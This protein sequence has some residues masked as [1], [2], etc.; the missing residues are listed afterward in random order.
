M[1]TAPLMVA[2]YDRVFV[3]ESFGESWRRRGRLY[4]GLAA[5]WALL[6]AVIASGP[7]FRSAGFG[8]GVSAWTYL[9]NQ[10]HMI[11]RYLGLAVWP[12][13]LVLDYGVPRPL[14]LGDVLP[15]GAIVLAL[16]ALTICTLST[17][18]PARAATR[19]RPVD[20]L[21]YE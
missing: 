3:F 7:R 10:A 18:Y 2:V 1:V 15:H 9:L 11:V 4:V 21:R 17:I 12:D 14:T 20:G 13:G 16:A 5:T 19:I 6:A 8:A